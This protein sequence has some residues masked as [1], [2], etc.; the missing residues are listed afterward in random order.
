MQKIAITNGRVCDPLQGDPSQRWGKEGTLLIEG[1]RIGSLLPP[2]AK[3]PTGYKIYDAK[4]CIVSPGFIDLHTHLRDPGFEYRED[5]QTGSRAA[6]AGGF[7]T[8]VCMANTQPVN[9]NKMVTQY[10]LQKAK[11]VG[12]IE[13]LPV[14]AV[15]KGLQ[16]KEMAE[17]G[18]MQK[19]GIVALS[20]DGMPVMNGNLMRRAM[21]YAKGFGLFVITHAEDHTLSGGSM[22]EGSC[23]CR[24][25][26]RGTPSIAEEA[27]IYRDVGLAELT[28]SHLHVA[29]VST[30]KGLEIIRNAKKRGVHVTC[31][32]TPHHLFLTEE[33]CENYNTYAKVNPPLRTKEDNQA[34]LKGLQ[35][36][37]VDAIA[38]DHA[39]HTSFEKERIPFE[40]AHFG[41]IGMETALP[42]LLHFVHKK[43]ISLERMVA[44][45]T[46]G[47]ARVLGRSLGTLK[48]GSLANIT[49]FDPKLPVTLG[50]G[51]YVS[52]SSNTP[53]TGLKLKGAVRATFYRGEKVFENSL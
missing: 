26:I 53:F 52:K 7:T 36:G 24:M 45:L 11:E 29:H 18:G 41:L 35:D 38:T 37:T 50:V 16:G 17:I 21:E 15:T 34:L 32:V 4:G 27:M 1:D 31:E 33:A 48:K 40:E 49:L 6:A 47:P 8:I 22:N 44:L 5:I 13:I 19:A 42:I 28:Q 39:P 46:E 20:D 25:G 51:G 12:V 23:S 3:V 9:D 43:E 10:I 30:A 2:R 14:G